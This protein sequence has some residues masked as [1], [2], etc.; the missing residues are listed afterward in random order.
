MGSGGG[1]GAW[2]CDAQ[3]LCPS[4]PF[5]LFH[6]VQAAWA[7]SPSLKHTNQ[8]SKASQDP[9]PFKQ[10]QVVSHDCASLCVV[11]VGFQRRSD[12]FQHKKATA[13]QIHW[14]NDEGF[15][16][17]HDGR[18]DT[19]HWW[20]GTTASGLGWR[21]CEHHGVPMP[22][23]VGS[24][25]PPRPALLPLDGLGASPHSDLAQATRV[26]H[27]LA[28]GPSGEEPLRP[29]WRQ[30]IPEGKDGGGGWLQDATPKV[31]CQGQHTPCVRKGK[32]AHIDDA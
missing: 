23:A 21:P 24:S 28:A 11:L 30:A 22:A 2:I 32:Q 27:A 15:T 26:P 9:S 1:Q 6:K 14:W 10:L 12:L 13:L 25:L 7:P 31:R 29:Q 20:A 17:G 8:N 18:L 3:R 5:P 4:T 19:T 16:A